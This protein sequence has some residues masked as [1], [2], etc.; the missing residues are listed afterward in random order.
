MNVAKESDIFFLKMI[1]N[2][3]YLVNI[4]KGGRLELKY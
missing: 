1:K 3:Y 2:N 4:M